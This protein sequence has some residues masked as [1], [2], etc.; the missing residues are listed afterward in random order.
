MARDKSWYFKQNPYTAS[1]PLAERDR[2][3]RLADERDLRK[4]EP[5]WM[6]GDAVRHVYLVRSGLL[7]TNRVSETGHELTLH[8]FQRNDLLGETELILQGA[9][10][11]PHETNCESLDESTVYALPAEAFLKAMQSHSQLAMDVMRLVADRRRSLERRIDSLLFKTAHA[12]LANLF[13]DLQH[14][15]G[16][17]DGRGTILNLKLTHREMASLIGASRET[18]SFAILDLRK[19]ALILTEDKRVV[20]LDEERL[21][22]L[23]RS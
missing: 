23:A 20:L 2:L 18:V 9:D 13:L 8:L 19:D 7:K 14:H 10:H 15:F 11:R 6:A 12:R 1:L 17:R 5:L 3:E 22:A 16:V 21:A 4:R